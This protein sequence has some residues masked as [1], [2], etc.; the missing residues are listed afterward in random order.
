MIKLQKS[1]HT[2]GLPGFQDTLKIEIEN[3]H[4]DLLPLQQGLRH[5]SHAVSDRFSVIILATS[6]DTD[7]L[8]IKAGIFYSGIIAGCNCADDPTPV[9]E[10]SE[11]CEIILDICKLTAETKVSLSN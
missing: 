10:Q 4:G 2:W 1:V 5:S 6:D 11:Y 9:D 7:F 3:L 8:H